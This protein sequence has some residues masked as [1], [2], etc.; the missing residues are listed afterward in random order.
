MSSSGTPPAVALFQLITGHY[1]SHAVYV[2]AK[3]GVADLLSDGAKHYM[4]VAARTTTHAP[5]LKRLFRLLASAGVLKDEGG[6][7]FSL[8]EMGSYLRSGFPASRRA[9]AMFFA[10]PVTQRPWG[11]LLYTVQTGRPA[12]DHVF[13]TDGYEFFATHPEE[14]AIFNEAMSGGHARAAEEIAASYDFAGHHVVVDVGG[15]QGGFLMAILRAN[16]DLH[17]V[18]MDRPHVAEVA[19]LRLAEAD[20]QERCTVIGGNFFEAVPPGGNVYILKSVLHGWDDERARLLLRNCRL[21]MPPQSKL[22]VVELIFPP[23]M[24]H[25]SAHQ[26]QAGSDINVMVSTTGSERTEEEFRALLR[27]EGF[28]INRIHSTRSPS[29]VIEA[30]PT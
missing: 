16:P 19:K 7:S 1:L 9:L 5:S 2:A 18:L 27:S 15:G 4:E 10:G 12:F 13:G 14:A 26:I 23:Q 11:E 3:L 6:G 17:G 30:D 24:Q 28:E 8:T 20:M 29:C 22:L 25:S 21:V